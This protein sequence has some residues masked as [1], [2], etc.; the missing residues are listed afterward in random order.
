MENASKK[1]KSNV[2]TIIAILSGVII[3]LLLFFRSCDD[4]SSMRVR[5]QKIVQPDTSQ[6]VMYITPRVV[7]RFRGS[8]ILD[9]PHVT[10]I[11]NVDRMGK[12]RLEYVE[13]NPKIISLKIDTEYGIYTEIPQNLEKVDP[14]TSVLKINTKTP[15]VFFVL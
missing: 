12:W 7:K 11:I 15:L 1:S 13:P 4:E 10:Y 8:I 9:N 14:R 5:E 2:G 3:L 6:T